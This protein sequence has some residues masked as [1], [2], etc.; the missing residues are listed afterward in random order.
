ME[1][2]SEAGQGDR[3]RNW[4]GTWNNPK[5]PETF[6]KFLV[7]A[8]KAKYAVGQLEAG[9]EGTHHLQFCVH[10]E[11]PVRFAA[12]KSINKRAHWEKV[13]EPQAA[14]RYCQKEDTRL[15]GP[16]V[17]GETPKWS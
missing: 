3:S 15:E 10:W 14:F 13:K 4:F 11:Q 5:E 16:W 1:F 9:A 17:Y 7:E 6:I 2:K 12:L 8:R